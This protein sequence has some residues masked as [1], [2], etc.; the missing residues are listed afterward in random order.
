MDVF[1]TAG[2]PTT[3]NFIIIPS[4]ILRYELF[5]YHQISEIMSLESIE[6]PSLF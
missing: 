2:S 5:Y 3:Q 4:Y 1:P 6:N